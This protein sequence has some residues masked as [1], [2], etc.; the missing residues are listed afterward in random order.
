VAR[1]LTLA[2]P[3]GRPAGEK[4][5]ARL[6]AR[7]RTSGSRSL[8]LFCVVLNG[9]ALMAE[10]VFSLARKDEYGSF[11]VVVAIMRGLPG[12]PGLFLVGVLGP[13]I[14]AV[15]VVICAARQLRCACII[16]GAR[17]FVETNGSGDCLFH[18]L[19]GKQET[20]ETKS[21][22][23]TKVCFQTSQQALV[24]PRRI[25]HELCRGITTL[26]RIYSR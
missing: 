10:Y 7:R 25:L 14:V 20:H 21:W 5:R 2:V 8:W 18:W 17:R 11:I 6:S 15:V 19:T 3:L 12:L 22:H 16:G 13:S 1:S 24:G 4:S 9:D 23:F 26:Q